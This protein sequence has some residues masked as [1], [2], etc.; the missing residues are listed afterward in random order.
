MYSNQIFFLNVKSTS[1]TPAPTES[2]A[3]WVFCSSNVARLASF[4]KSVSVF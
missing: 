2:V 4:F 1:L 3:L